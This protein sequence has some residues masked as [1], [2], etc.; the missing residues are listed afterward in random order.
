MTINGQA[1]FNFSYHGVTSKDTG[2]NSGNYAPPAWT[3][4]PR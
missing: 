1:T 4:S 2:S 3:R